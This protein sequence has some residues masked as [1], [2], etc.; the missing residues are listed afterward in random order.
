MNPEI[1]ISESIE[2]EIEKHCFSETQVEVG[3]F[4][5]GTIDGGRTNIS[6]AL[7]P[8]SCLLFH[9]SGGAYVVITYSP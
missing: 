9:K 7:L 6:A 8:V 5:V 3:G 2:S 4:L 1:V